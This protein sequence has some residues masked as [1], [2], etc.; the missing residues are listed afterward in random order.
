MLRR[1]LLSLL[2]GLSVVCF[3]AELTYAQTPTLQWN[4]DGRS[5]NIGG[6]RV[7]IDGV[8]IDHGATA[9][10]SDGTCNCSVPVALNGGSHTI[11]VTAYNSA[12]QTAS[13]P[14]TVG[15]T[16]DVSGPYAGQAG[17]SITVSGA[18]SL[19][20]T[21]TLTS[22]AW[23][24]GDGSADTISASSSATHVYAS[25][26]TFTVTLTVTDNA[27]ATA[28]ATTSATISSAAPSL[29]APW[30]TQDI[31]TVGRAGSASFT[32]GRFTITGAGG[33]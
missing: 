13:A 11:V 3:G 22:Y 17:N 32:S 15:P 1:R 23:R 25:T 8:T 29:P 16:A 21:G 9:L 4:G 19:A 5:N 18:A 10:R 24:W 28:S 14:L 20:P 31:G 30:Q 12:G 27:G 26:G 2:A 6:Y 33:D 7:T